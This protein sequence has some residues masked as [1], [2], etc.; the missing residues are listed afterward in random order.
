M[1]LE[2]KKSGLQPSSVQAQQYRLQY[3]NLAP[4]GV[5]PDSTTNRQPAPVTSPRPTV[6][7]FASAPVYTS[8]PTPV[9]AVSQTPAVVPST[10]RQ[11]AFFDGATVYS[12]SLATGNDF[13]FEYNNKAFSVDLTFKPA[14]PD[15]LRHTIFHTYSGSFMSQS[16]ELFITGSYLVLELTNGTTTFN[17]QV[18]EQ[19]AH[20]TRDLSYLE[21]IGR[22]GHMTNGFTYFSA[23][24]QNL[25]GLFVD[26][27]FK[28]NSFN[29]NSSI[30]IPPDFN[31]SNN[32]HFYVGGSPAKNSYFSGSIASMLFL[33]GSTVT[34]QQWGDMAL[35]DVNPTTVSPQLR[36]YTFNNTP[37][38][39]TGSQASF[40]RPLELV[41]GTLSY[42]D[43][44]LKL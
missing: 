44:Y 34:N 16:L 19:R 6:S 23:R 33:T 27:K 28:A 43:S 11:A 30:P 5:A 38:E 26:M 3:S 13:I 20:F 12:A 35:R 36:T 9:P 18:V 25:N 17:G 31:T 8:V 32:T 1:A 22:T 10:F 42:V 40:S 4:A 39:F 14:A 29:T 24:I 21:S 37:A 15:S 2:D 41:A 7:A